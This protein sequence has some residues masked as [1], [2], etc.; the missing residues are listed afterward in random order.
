MY[1]SSLFKFS[2][3]SD[4]PAWPS[5]EAVPTP[6]LGR[7]DEPHVHPLQLFLVIYLDGVWDSGS[8]QLP[9]TAE[10][11]LRDDDYAALDWR[12]PYKVSIVTDEG[13]E[14]PSA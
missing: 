6:G 14:G 2:P 10:C 5:P 11:S 12:Q 7:P 9:V 8:W 3:R 1:L 4:S 13:A